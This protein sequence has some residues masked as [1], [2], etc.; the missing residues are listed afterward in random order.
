MNFLNR[1]SGIKK[2]LAIWYVNSQNPDKSATNKCHDKKS[3]KFIVKKLLLY[4]DKFFRTI[5]FLFLSTLLFLL[6]SFLVILITISTMISQMMSSIIFV[7]TFW[8]RQKNKPRM[9]Q[10]FHKEREA[11]QRLTLVVDLDNTLI[12]SSTKKIA[13]MK[14]YTLIDGRF[15]VYKRPHL[16]SFLSTLSQYCELVIYTAGTKEYADKVIDHIDK[17][18]VISRRFYRNNCRQVENMWFKDFSRLEP[19]NKN[20]IIIDDLPDCHTSFQG[21]CF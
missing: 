5:I 21:N 13:K 12:Y 14:N 2:Q 18:S 19:D 8:K 1:I 11:S 16:E 20:V 4:I 9:D 10:V 6:N 3:L 17:N 15:Y 7:F